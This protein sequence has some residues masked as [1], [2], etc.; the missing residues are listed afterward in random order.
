MKKIIVLDRDG[1]INEDSDNYIKSADEWNPVAGSIEAIARLKKAGYL[2]AVATNQSG[3]KRGLYDRKTL[4][5]MH[6]KLQAL[7]AEQQVG[8]DWI[9][10]S[11]YLGDCNSVCRKP[12]TGMLRAIEKRFDLSLQGSVMVGDTL[13]DLQVAAAMQMQGILVRSGKGERT[14]KLDEPLVKQAIQQ[15][16]V[17]KNLLDFVEDFLQ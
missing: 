7:L 4:S 5:Q 2:V 11:P 9:N 14:I 15:E 16:K 1:V 8:V 13:A 10:F 12:L 17:Y 6:L 3:L